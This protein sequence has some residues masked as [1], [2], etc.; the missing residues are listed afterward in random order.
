MSRRGVGSVGREDRDPAPS[1]NALLNAGALARPAGPVRRPARQA[2][3]SW[4]RVLVSTVKLAVSRR[5]WAAGLRRRGAGGSRRWPVRR[6][7]R[8]AILVLA[9][10]GAAVT[11]LWLAGGLTGAPSRAVRGPTAGAGPPSLAA[12]VQ[13]RAAAWI[14]GQVSGNSIVAC[15]PGM[16]AALQEQGVAAGRLMPLR[17]AAASPLG[18]SVLVTSPPVNGQLAGRYAPALIASFGSGGNRVEV[19]AVEPGGASAYRAALRADLVARRAAGSQLLRNSHIRFTGPGAAQLRAGAVDTR[20]LA[21]LAALAAQYS[22]RVTGFGDAAPGGPVLF[23]EVSITGV[24]GGV[25]A[26][27]AMVRAQNPPYLP[28]HAVAVGQT[29]LSIEFAAPSPLGLLSPVLDAYSPRPAA[30]GGGF[31]VGWAQIR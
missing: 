13:G 28:A 6:R 26:A 10:G 29:G 23:R 2:E 21:T 9:L 19:R 20:L 18:A 8:F 27:L 24:G 7:W 5:L 1:R 4:G 17:S 16:C 12:G 14:A 25:S 15:D 11:V 31:P 3:P 22:F 30:S